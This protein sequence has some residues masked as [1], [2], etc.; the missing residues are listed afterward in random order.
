M[1]AAGRTRAVC[2]IRFL[3]PPR[4][5][6]GA[7]TNPSPAWPPGPIAELLLALPGYLVPTRS[8]A[9]HC[10]HGDHKNLL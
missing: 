3:P 10:L 1:D 9:Q 7:K 8:T 6:P 2:R 4:L 5:S